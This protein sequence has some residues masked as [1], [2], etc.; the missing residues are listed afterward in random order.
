MRDISRR[1]FLHTTVT[2][3]AA[4]TLACHS[5][6]RAAQGDSDLRIAV[7][8][9]GIRG[10]GRHLGGF[11]SNVVAVC[12]CDESRVVRHASKQK[13]IEGF[14]DYRKLLERDDID[15]VSIATPNHTHAIIAIAAAQAGKDVYVEK[16]I[17]HNVWEGRQLV[18]AA[19]KYDRIIQCGTQI[20]SNSAIRSGCPIRC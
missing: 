5:S 15:A 7:I 11:G 12:D 14:I 16:P 10:A 20:R 8:G 6:V 18:N 3:S 2:A 9:L 17:S 13:N 1:Q 19:R 4:T